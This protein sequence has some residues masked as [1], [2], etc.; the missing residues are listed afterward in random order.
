MKRVTDAGP[1]LQEEEASGLAKAGGSRPRLVDPA[2]YCTSQQVREWPSPHS[3]NVSLN[4]LYWTLARL[5]C[6]P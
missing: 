3:L 5:H 4:A 2:P 1:E 6:G